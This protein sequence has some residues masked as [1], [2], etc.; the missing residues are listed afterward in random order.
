MNVIGEINYDEY[1]PKN[2]FDFSDWTHLTVVR[3]EVSLDRLKSLLS[4]CVTEKRD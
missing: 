1:T 2:I 3:Q 4:M